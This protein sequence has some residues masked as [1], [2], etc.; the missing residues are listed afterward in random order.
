[1]KRLPFQ[2]KRKSLRGSLIPALET[3]FC[4]QPVKR[5]IQFDRIEI[6]RIEFEP[7]S[8]GEVGRVEDTIPPMGIVIAARADMIIS[9]MEAD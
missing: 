9:L 3:F 4:G 6:V 7:F 5:D 8:L 1:M 2:S